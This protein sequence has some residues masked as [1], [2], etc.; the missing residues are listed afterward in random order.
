MMTVGELAT[1]IAG[2]PDEAGTQL[3]NI[4]APNPSAQAAIGVQMVA[5]TLERDRVSRE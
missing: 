5:L 3:K 1:G 2:L 4:V